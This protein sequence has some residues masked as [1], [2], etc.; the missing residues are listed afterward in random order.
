[1][2]RTQVSLTET[3]NTAEGA[4]QFE[5]TI[6]GATVLDSKLM[7]FTVKEAIMYVTGQMGMS[8]KRK[9]QA[10]YVSVGNGIYGIDG[11]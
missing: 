9:V 2:T 4:S 11:I 1:M 6:A 5:K 7:S 10:D 3:G 8:S